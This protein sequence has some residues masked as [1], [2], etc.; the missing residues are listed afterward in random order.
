MTALTQYQRL[1]ATGLWREGAGAQ[2]RE[3]VVS[4]GDAT[5]TVSD[6]NDRAL[7][8]WSLAAIARAN[9]GE[10]PAL[11]HPDGDPDETLELGED[12]A[13]MVGAI[14]KLRGAIARRRPHPGRLRLM[15]FAGSLAA[16]VALAVFWV[17]GAL[18]GHALSV[19]PEAKRQ[20]LGNDLRGAMERYTGPA[21]ADPAATAALRRLAQR[22]PD[23]AGRVPSLVVVRGGVPGALAL[24]GAVLLL[25][26]RL[27]ED[28]E[29]PDVVAGYIIAAQ[30]RAT[31][32]DPLGL[33]LDS[34]GVRSSFRLLTTGQVG[35]TALDRHAGVLASD[36][37]AP[38]PEA[39]LLAAFATAGVRAS[40]YAY[41]VDITG[42]TTLGLIE[43]DPFARDAPP[44]VVLSDS[45]WLRLQA[46]CGN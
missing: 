36:T 1:E 20:E 43:A 14:D 32:D 5:L 35:D 7:A 44:D 23:A 25:D 12:A 4:L 10:M 38:V 31:L 13:E 16:V 30:T 22:L 42:E 18:R 37:P 33:L 3:V 27:I 24:P 41:A 45:D 11:Y 34:G 6:M 17:P 28:H 39:A 29:D 19:V 40:P 15:A 26:A 46:I 9:P 2:R 8:H 21:C